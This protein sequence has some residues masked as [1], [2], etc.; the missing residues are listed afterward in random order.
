M[1]R[2]HWIAIALVALPLL[3]AGALWVLGGRTQVYRA[4]IEIEAPPEE[5]FP[6]L[7]EPDR[8]AQWVDGLVEITPLTEGGH[9][10]GA[11]A[12]LVVEQDGNRYE[13]ID[14]VTSTTANESLELHSQSDMF[15]AD[16]RWELEPSKNGTHAT[17][18]MRTDFHGFYR[19]LAP[20]MRSTAEEQLQSDFE[21]LKQLIESPPSEPAEPAAPPSE[22]PP[23]EPLPPEA[24][25]GPDENDTTD[26]MMT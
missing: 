12:R 11:T 5:V 19:F 24:P 14:E 15:D 4:E 20:M 25:A 1:K 26:W 17:A 10:V 21:R 9:R 13:F 8:I 3:V 6:Y 16:I 7:T 18:V 22:E 23:A 2:W